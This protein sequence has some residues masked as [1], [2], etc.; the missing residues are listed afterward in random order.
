MLNSAG[1]VTLPLVYAPPI[2]MT[3]LTRSAMRGSM[4]I[5]SAIF[6]NGPTATRLTV[7]GACAMTVS[8]M[9]STPWRRSSSNAGGD[10]RLDPRDRAHGKRVAGDLL[11]RLVARDGGDPEQFDL[12][13]S[14][15]EQNGDRVVVTRIAVQDDLLHVVLS[16]RF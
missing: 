7:P 16:R 10:R 11:D 5:A 15:R 3:D 12:G 4:R 2:T 9:K 13:I 6:V 14:R 1:G 8:T